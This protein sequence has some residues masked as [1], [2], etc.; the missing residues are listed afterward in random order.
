MDPMILLAVSS[1]SS[2]F[3]VFVVKLS[4]ECLCRELPLVRDLSTLSKWDK[5]DKENLPWLLVYVADS[6]PVKLVDVALQV[7]QHRIVLLSVH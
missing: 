1:L 5:S 3:Q 6:N 7:K 2:S 4:P